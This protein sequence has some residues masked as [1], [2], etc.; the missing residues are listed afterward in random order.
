MSLYNKDWAK[1]GNKLMRQRRELASKPLP[2][3]ASKPL[4]VSGATE[5]KGN[6][7]ESLLIFR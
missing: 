7:D 4:L 5:R 6:K 1:K 2:E 3:L